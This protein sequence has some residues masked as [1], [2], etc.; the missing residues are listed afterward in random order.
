M[1]G[2]KDALLLFEVVRESRRSM[3]ALPILAAMGEGFGWF[4]ALWR[5]ESTG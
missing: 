4:V 5:Q 3:S 1:A 2:L